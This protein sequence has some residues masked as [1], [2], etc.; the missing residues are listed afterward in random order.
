MRVG[1]ADGLANLLH[2]ASRQKGIRSYSTS[3]SALLVPL[4]LSPIN[5]NFASPSKS[6][7]CLSQ[8][9][10]VSRQPNHNTHSPK[11]PNRPPNSR[12]RVLA[13]LHQQSLLHVQ[14][15]RHTQHAQRN[16][17]SFAG[18]A[19]GFHESSQK[20][21]QRDILDEICLAAGCYEE[22]VRCGFFV[23]GGRGAL[24][25]GLLGGHTGV[26]HTGLEKGVVE[27]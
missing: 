21:C 16:S 7:D 18:A 3:P 15:P 5:L 23:V 2:T 17:Q 24:G 12:V 20:E 11:E 6:P 27:S 14:H 19:V 8:P 4:C 13:I 22:R 25:D 10:P 9:S 1:T 26:D